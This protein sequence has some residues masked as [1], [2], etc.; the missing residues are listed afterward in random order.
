MTLPQRNLH[1]H[2][3]SL[4]SISG[5]LCCRLPT[6]LARHWF[7]RAVTFFPQSVRIRPLLGVSS[8]FR[9]FLSSC[10]P[11]PPTLAKLGIRS[12]FSTTRP[13]SPT[14]LSSA[15]VDVELFAGLEGAQNAASC[16]YQF[17]GPTT[18]F[19]F[20]IHSPL[21]TTPVFLQPRCWSQSLVVLRAFSAPTILPQT[22]LDRNASKPTI[23][24]VVS[25]T[26]NLLFTEKVYSK[27]QS[28]QFVQQSNC[29]SRLR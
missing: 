28:Q 8:T 21:S 1:P 11:A 24:S 12:H 14:Q 6:L 15:D 9:R 7:G 10:H 19:P 5:R 2:P 20:S 27:T 16:N 3:R 13:L 23:T 17:S 29:R 4:P 25:G 18:P 22:S 26:R